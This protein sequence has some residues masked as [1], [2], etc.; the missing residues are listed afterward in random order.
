MDKQ[1]ALLIVER[2]IPPGNGRHHGKILDI[3]MLTLFGSQERTEVEYRN[4]LTTAGFQIKSI[5]PTPV[6]IDIIEA[7][8]F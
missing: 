8:P 7:Y 3:E 5:Q 1:A 2:V 6:E 4:L